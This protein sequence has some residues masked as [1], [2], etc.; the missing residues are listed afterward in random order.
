MPSPLHPVEML[1]VA[2][3]HKLASQSL[4]D[5]VEHRERPAPFEDP[6]RRFTVRRLA[7]LLRDRW[8]DR[9]KR[10]INDTMA[11]F[12]GVLFQW[13]SPISKKTK[14]NWANVRN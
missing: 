10:S 13:R 12:T 3:M 9:L 2:V 5:S 4:H 14:R 11:V 7:L 6:L 8:A 1:W